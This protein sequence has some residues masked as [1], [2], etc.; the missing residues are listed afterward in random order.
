[1]T[2]KFLCRLW[3]TFK[4]QFLGLFVPWLPLICDPFAI[5][6][7]LLI[8]YERSIIS[9]CITGIYFIIYQTCVGIISIIISYCSLKLP[10]KKPQAEYIS[11]SVRLYGLKVRLIAVR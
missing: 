8:I 10:L 5:D 7:F 3:Q 11:F 9:D 1:M 2:F 6:Q 4:I